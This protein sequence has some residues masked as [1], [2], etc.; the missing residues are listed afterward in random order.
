MLIQKPVLQTELCL[1]SK[2]TQK[3]HVVYTFPN[4]ER[5]VKEKLESIGIHSFLPM[6]Q[7]VRDWS[8]RKKKLIV[9]LF[10]NY[11]FLKAP[12]DR[13]HDV[14]SIKEIIRYVS[15]GGKPATIDESV[16]DSLQNLIKQNWPMSIQSI[17]MA[18]TPVKITEGPFMGTEGVLVRS[19]G[20]S[21]LIV[22]IHSLQREVVVNISSTE[23]EPI[24][25]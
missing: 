2:L 11:I 13:R 20:G 22:Q 15:F 9:P 5:K 10:P 7:V 25:T 16:I 3:W 4:A 12:P 1:H 6:H 24:Q 21:R 23:V 8:D 17:A 19:N 18:G 14:F